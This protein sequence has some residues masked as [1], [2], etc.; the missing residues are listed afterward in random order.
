LTITASSITGFDMRSTSAIAFLIILITL[1]YGVNKVFRTQAA[2]DLTAS[3]AYKILSP[4]DKSDILIMGSSHAD[5]IIANYLKINH[6]LSVGKFSIPGSNP[7]YN[8]NLYTK[9]FKK[10]HENKPSLVIYCVDWFIFDDVNALRRKIDND[11][12]CL[13]RHIYASE[14][15][16][17]LK[18]I[19][20][21]VSCLF[22]VFRV[23]RNNLSHITRLLP[24]KS[25]STTPSSYRDSEDRARAIVGHVSDGQFYYFIKLLEEF[26]ADKIKVLLVQTPE[27]LKVKYG[28]SY[29][30]NNNI[31]NQIADLYGLEY[32][33]YNHDKA[34]SIN[35]DKNNYADWGHLNSNG[36]VAFTQLFNYDLNKYVEN[37]LLNRARKDDDVL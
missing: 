28:A 8:Y 9:Y 32:L 22:P 2:V 36:A 16:Y 17:N 7:E 33:N 29:A 3:N 35:Y 20:K 15:I 4:E 37:T 19:Q 34:S 1:F 25:V 23:D 30:H 24:N 6:G 27:Y 26:K 13:P 31:L 10:Y 21:Y 5:G 18:D 11:Y 14:S 12:S